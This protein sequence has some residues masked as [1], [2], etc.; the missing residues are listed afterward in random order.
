[1][2]YFILI[3]SLSFSI[4]VKAQTSQDSPRERVLLQTTKGDI[5]LELY[6]ETPKHRDNFLKLV[7]EGFYD[8]LLFHRVIFRFMIQAGD[9]LSRNA[10]P[11]D[12]LGRSSVD[13]TVPKEILFPKYY[14]KRGALAA[15]RA[16]DEV[17]PERNSSGSQFY[18]VYGQR[19]NDEMLDEAQAKLDEAFGGVIKLTPE[20]REEYKLH[21]GCPSLD[22][23]YTVFGEVVEGLDIVD[24]IQR[25]QTNQMGRPIE[26]IRIIKATILE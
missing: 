23:Q 16:S 5:L 24:D 20:I 17:N 6:N 13:Y 12:V 18:I 11:D 25:Q 7:N 14:H 15:A 10:L 21:G 3:L 1:M 22:G 2:R 4:L 26:D 9:S 19:Y 8:G